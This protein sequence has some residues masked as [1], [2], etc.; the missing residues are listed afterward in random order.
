MT[1]FFADLER[2]LVA[3]AA[4]ER[5]VRPPRP[6][7]AP[8][9]AL[10][11]TVA[12]VVALV[13]ALPRGDTEVAGD[14]EQAPRPPAG[15]HEPTDAAPPRAWS[16]TLA[17]L[18][19]PATDAER[20]FGERL[21]RDL[22]E[23]GAY[24]RFA[25]LARVV[26]GREY[27][28]VPVQDA[29]MMGAACEEDLD[30]LPGVCVYVVEPGGRGI[31]NC[32]MPAGIRTLNEWM[33]RS[34]Q[35]GGRKALEIVGVMPNTVARMRMEDRDLGTRTFDV[36]GNVVVGRVPVEHGSELDYARWSYLDHAG[37]EVAAAGG[38]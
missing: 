1:D 2:H 20:E 34:V 25:R 26:D 17:V 19:R 33:G 15:C 7:A 9:L 21:P 35:D 24:R 31:V 14:R 12:A 3:A 36:V 30:D 10:A 18:D 4:T 6:R 16:R 32:S 13:I 8:L 27:W 23:Q 22:A 38:G 37:R 11:V 28:L 29:R 5:R